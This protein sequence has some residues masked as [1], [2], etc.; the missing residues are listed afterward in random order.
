MFAGVLTDLRSALV[1]NH[2]F[3]GLAVKWGFHK[4]FRCFSPSLWSL[5]E[6]FVEYQKVTQDDDLD[7]ITSETVSFS[8]NAL[9]EA[10]Q[11]PSRIIGGCISAV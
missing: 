3:A 7:F 9:I 11:L 2:I 10:S 4:F 1:N 5:I 6:R 8:Q